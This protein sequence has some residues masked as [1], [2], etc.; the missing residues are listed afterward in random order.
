M[1][2]W[3]VLALPI[4]TLSFV[5]CCAE[6]VLRRFKLLILS[7][8][9]SS[10]VMSHL[11]QGLIAY[12]WAL[13]SHFTWLSVSVFMNMLMYFLS[14]TIWKCQFWWWRVLISTGQRLWNVL[15]IGFSAS[16]PSGTH[17]NCLLQS[18]I[19]PLSW[20]GCH[21][22]MAKHFGLQSFPSRIQIL[23]DD[24]EQ[25][26]SSIETTIERKTKKIVFSACDDVQSLVI[27][28]AEVR[29]KCIQKALPKN[30]PK[31]EGW[32]DLQ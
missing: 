27:A 25:W 8:R 7:C 19:N 17:A 30:K 18:N 13:A 16:F 22:I 31:R 26:L 15:E 9:F 28:S 21:D 29:Y 5:L 2:E 23:W 14:H 24:H 3:N 11:F 4:A 12:S 10:H 20:A 32:T 1:T 6:V